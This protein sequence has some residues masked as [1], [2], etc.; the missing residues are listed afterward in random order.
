MKDER[1]ARPLLVAKLLWEKTDKKHYLTGEELCDK[2]Y[3]KFDVLTDRRT[4]YKDIEVLRRDFGMDIQGGSIFY[5]A[6]RDLSISDLTLLAE[7]VYAAKFISEKEAQ[8]L[9]D[10][11]CKF[12]STH[13]GEELRKNIYLF[14]RI[15]KDYHGTL[16]TLSTIREAMAKSPRRRAKEIQFTYTT[17]SVEDV[18]K[19]IPRHNGKVY[20][21]RPYRLILNA[22]NYYLLALD[23]NKELRTYRVD[24][25]QDVKILLENDGRSFYSDYD[26]EYIK[27]RKADQRIKGYLQ[28][29]FSMFSGEP[30]KVTMCFSNHLIDAVIDKFGIDNGTAYRPVGEDKFLVTTTV[31][32][33]DQF[34]GWLCGF[35]TDAKIVE[36]KEVAKQMKSYVRDI[37]QSYVKKRE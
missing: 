23:E 35:H 16:E 20:I 14:D 28:R 3:T 19:T 30:T 11:L 36:P 34:F 7:C 31:E 4:L 37:F 18:R 25:M 15:K 1:R 29:T 8:E 2:L 21:V 10:I 27:L 33:S 32:V 17:H 26:E 9:I 5:L 22:D 6:S 12:C 13:Q 24:R